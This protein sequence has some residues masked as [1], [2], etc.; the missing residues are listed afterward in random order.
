MTC[1]YKELNARRR[2]AYAKGMRIDIR[3][4]CV[5]HFLGDRRYLKLDTL[6]IHTF[7]VTYGP[8]TTMEEALNMLILLGGGPECRA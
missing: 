6:T 7:G 8:F 2:Q 1:T 3:N 4:G 5:A